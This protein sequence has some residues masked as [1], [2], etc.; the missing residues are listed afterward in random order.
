MAKTSTATVRLVIKKNRSNS[1]GEHP[2]YIVVC[3]RGRKEVSTGVFIQERYW[4]SL[5]EEIR[6][7]CPNAVA[8]NRVIN[9]Y[10]LKIMDKRNQYDYEKKVY[11]ASMLFEENATVNSLLFKDL[12]ENYISEK[13][14]SAS[15]SKLYRYNYDVFKKFLKK[16]NILITEITLSV[17]KRLISSIGQSDNS[18]RG[19]CG[20]FAAIWNYACSKGLVSIDNYPFKD[21][22]YTR[23]FKKSNRLY[24]LDSTNLKK[25]R[26]YFFETYLNIDGE[27]FSCKDF[28]GL[29]KRY[30]KEFSLL[31]FLMCYRINGAS[32][33]DVALLKGENCSRTTINGVD[34]WKI[35]FKRKKT[36]VPVTCLLKRDIL[37]MV[38]F[39]HF[40][41]M[42][43][44][45]IY[46]IL[47]VG[48]SD[49]QINNSIAK[50]VGYASKYL[51]EI[52]TVIN[53]KTI[54]NNVKNNLEEPLID[55]EQMTLYVARHT[56]ANDYLSH[57]GATLQALATLL[58]R[59][60]NT[61]GVYV[62][63]LKSDIEIAQA[64]SL[65]TI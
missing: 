19:I 55:V 54:E 13:A 49:K 59:S 32:P 46:P 52:C 36:G 42:S 41:G 39:E 58:G 30:T 63:Q 48:I 35:Q 53:Q 2:I 45:Y 56:F 44:G 8:L 3:W 50:F 15:S 37:T 47:K 22:K 62:H 6:K 7:T 5:R 27:L 34:Y 26:D 33:I 11:T 60:V 23:Q 17:I 25:L 1:N 10:K 57:P 64:E 29:H 18:I 28:D 43:K 20:R 12:T 61:L 38:G 4:N 31:F 24:Y 9:S 51:K 21:W 65:T 14:L 40:L 16:D